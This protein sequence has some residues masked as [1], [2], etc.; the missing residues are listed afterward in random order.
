MISGRHFVYSL[1]GNTHSFHL[2]LALDV[3]FIPSYFCCYPD[4]ISPPGQWNRQL[5]RF[6]CFQ[7]IRTQVAFASNF[8]N[9]FFF[10]CQPW[11]AALSFT[12]FE[13]NFLWYWSFLYFYFTSLLFVNR[14]H[15]SF[16]QWVSSVGI[17]F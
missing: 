10:S 16:S 5:P 15:Y 8:C 9:I 11:L 13:L 1:T 14:N 12:S 6:I 3:T 4:R 17:I 7:G 2:A